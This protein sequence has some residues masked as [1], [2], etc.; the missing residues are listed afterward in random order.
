MRLA[1]GSPVRQGG[2]C[3]FI[4]FFY[5]SFLYS[6]GL[7]CKW[8]LSNS[9]NLCQRRLWLQNPGLPRR[10]KMGLHFGGGGGLESC[11]VVF[12]FGI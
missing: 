1:L 5:S 9:N 3:D 10:A 11:P 6:L 8:G 7:L 4:I 12:C 2:D